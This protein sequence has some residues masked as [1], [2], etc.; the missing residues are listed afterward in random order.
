MPKFPHPP[1]RD[2][3]K[4]LARNGFSIVGRKGSHIRLKKKDSVSTRIVV[5]PDHQ[6]MTPGTLHSIIRQSG[7]EK[8]EFLRML[9]EI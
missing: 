3:L 4:L 7:I 6:E 9:E 5:V 1:A 2:V 8:D